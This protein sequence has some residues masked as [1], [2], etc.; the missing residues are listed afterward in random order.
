M[1]FI[2]LKKVHSGNYIHRYD[3]TYETESGDK[4]VYEMISRNGDISTHEELIGQRPDA[5]VMIIFDETGEKILLNKEFRLATGEWVYN[6][7][8]GLIDGDETPEQASK[9]ELFEETGLNL[10]EV[11]DVIPISYSAVGFANETNITVVGKASGNIRE[12]D[13]EVEEIEAA[14]YTKEEV[15]ELISK[16][17]FA[18]RTQSFCYAWSR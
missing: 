2:S 14:W 17:R 16:Y 1:K 5:V 6:F 10:D 15:K 9:R 3:V 4:K 18:A 8:A 12:S 11:T 7:P 13:S